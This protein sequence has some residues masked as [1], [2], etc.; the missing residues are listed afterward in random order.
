MAPAW[1][2]FLALLV[3]CADSFWVDDSTIGRAQ[4]S[5]QRTCPPRAPNLAPL[6]RARMEEIITWVTAEG[7]FPR[8]SSEEKCERSMAQW[9]SDGRREAGDGTLSPAYR[10][11]LACVL[12]WEGNHRAAADEA[13]W[14]DRLRQLVDFRAEGNDWPCHH[15]CA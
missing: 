9:L 10:E 8:D 5:R 4:G 14:Q 6:R 1:R 7:P 2:L 3:D 13:R 12:G 15:D 11:G